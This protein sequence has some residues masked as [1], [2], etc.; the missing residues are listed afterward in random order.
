MSQVN[1][2]ALVWGVPLHAVN[3]LLHRL[4]MGFDAPQGDAN[5]GVSEAAVQN[6]IRLEAAHKNILLFRNNVG[7]LQDDTGRPVRYGLCND[8]A[9][10]N[11]KIKSGDLIGIKPVLITPAMIGHTIGQFVS[12]ECKPGGW[13]YTATPHEVAQSKW[14]E[15][16][17][18]KGGDASFA[19]G[20]GSL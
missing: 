15:V 4:G 17:E 1:E 6:N 19:T 16:I 11:R 3:D 7:V 8:S 2:W 18:S 10:L 20:T 12:R 9:A 5:A 13:R 14:I